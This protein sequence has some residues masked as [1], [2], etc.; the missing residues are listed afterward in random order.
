MSSKGH[1]VLIL[2]AWT[3]PKKIE[4]IS[5]IKIINVNVPTTQRG[6]HE[7]LSFIRTPIV[8]IEHLI[9]SIKAYKIIREID[10]LMREE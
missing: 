10:W 3:G 4:T 7:N 1:E 9:F 8:L 6:F 5:G 2:R